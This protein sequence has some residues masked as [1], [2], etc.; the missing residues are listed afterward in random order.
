MCFEDTFSSASLL[1]GDT[2]SVTW[3]IT[4]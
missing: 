4:I 1:N 3:T 2:L